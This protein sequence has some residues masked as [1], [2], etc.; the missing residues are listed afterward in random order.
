MKYR[1]LRADELAELETEFIRFLAS[2][3][4]PGPDWEKMKAEQKE[5]AEGIIDL[6]SDLVYEKILQGIEYLEHRSP[7]DLKTFHCGKEKIVMRGMMVEGRSNIDFTKDQSPE[8]M[9]GQIKLSNAQVKVYR[10][11]KKYKEGREKELFQMMETG[12]LIS[13]EGEIFKLLEGFDKD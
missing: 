8:Q 2:Q 6:F 5:K 10:A 3:S 11:E 7:H 12:C 4:I 9:L 13:K 1:R